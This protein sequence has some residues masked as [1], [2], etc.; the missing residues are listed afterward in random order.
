MFTFNRY[1]T[2]TL[3]TPGTE[4]GGRSQ[5]WGYKDAN[6]YSMLRVL[7]SVGLL[8]EKNEPTDLYLRYMNIQNGASVLADPIKKLYQPLFNAS[9]APYNESL[10]SL[11][12]L[13]NIHSGGS[14][15]TLDQQI[16]T[17]KALSDNTSFDGNNVVKSPPTSPLNLANK[18]STGQDVT[19]V[20]PAININLHIHLPENKTRRDYEY[21]IEDI[22]RYIFGRA[23]PESKDE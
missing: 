13:F 17:F 1:P 19:Q 20:G 11:K 18:Q 6:D 8:N 16:Q 15:H 10:D 7:K 12:N 4:N 14:E 2:N 23:N 21:I 22:A 5:S 9:H 3:I